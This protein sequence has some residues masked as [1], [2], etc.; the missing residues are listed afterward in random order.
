MGAI[1][2][3]NAPTSKRNGRTLTEN[4]RKTHDELHFTTNSDASA[5]S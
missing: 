1:E 5:L 4:L 3:Q 2:P